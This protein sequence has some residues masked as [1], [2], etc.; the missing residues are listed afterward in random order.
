M[1]LRGG[2]KRSKPGFQSRGGAAGVGK[3]LRQQGIESEP[4]PATETTV[5]PAAVGETVPKDSRIVDNGRGGSP[6]PKIPSVA[7][8]GMPFDDDRRLT[9]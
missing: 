9:F 5:A 2:D 3:P 1:P 7:G 4:I 8:G 6:P